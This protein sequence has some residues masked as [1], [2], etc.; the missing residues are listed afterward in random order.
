M[1][2]GSGDPGRRYTLRKR[3]EEFGLVL[4]SFFFALKRRQR[5]EGAG[6]EGEK[7]RRGKK[8][9]RMP[10]KERVVV[11]GAGLAGLRIASELEERGGMEVLLLEARERVGGRV[12]TEK[13]EGGRVLYE[14]GPWRVPSTH[15]RVIRL[16]SELGVLLVPLPTPTPLYPHSQKGSCRGLSTWDAEALASGD[17]SKADVADLETAYADET[18]SACGSAPYKTDTDEF[19]VSPSG[20]SEAIER[21]SKRLSK[22]TLRLNTRV[23]DIEKKK[24]RGY[25]VTVRERRN[26]NSFSPHKTVDCDSVF[27]CVP[28]SVCREWGAMRRFA[29]STLSAVKEGELAHL[30]VRDAEFERGNH[31]LY[32]SSLVSQ[33]VSSEYEGSD[34]FQAAYVGGRLA[35]MWQNL[36][37]QAPTSFLRI[38]REEVE[39]WTGHSIPVASEVRHHH[40]PVAYHAWRAVPDFSLS[41]SVRLSVLPNPVDL[42][43][44]YIAGEAFSSH[45]AWMEGA[46]ETAEMSIDAFFSPP[47][48]PPPKSA[49]VVEGREVDVS[50]W[51]KVHPGGSGAISNYEGEDLTSLVSHIGH[52]PHAWAVVHSLKKHVE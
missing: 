22:E 52:S 15:R 37:L 38:L 5:E 42:P 9:K 26:K 10:R 51:K 39:K 23:V 29:R 45:Q 6:G 48:K 7:E 28:P 33:V 24:G 3:E 36:H 47:P 46:L 49:T 13:G 44:L 32:P 21:L 19:Y 4:P 12:W 20:F 2:A 30:Y 40:W 25:E 27:V 31:T 35:R 11:V 50:K 8:K 41:K 43:N 34:Y 17:P 16:F 1:V 18:H 14:R